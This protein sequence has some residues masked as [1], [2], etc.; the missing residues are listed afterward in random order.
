MKACG[1]GEDSA[2]H[3]RAGTPQSGKVLIANGKVRHTLRSGKQQTG[4]RGQGAM[5]KATK[6][7]PQKVL[8]R[9]AR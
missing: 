8:Q 2:G 3:A 6:A 1:V 5:L 4:I 7:W 9:S